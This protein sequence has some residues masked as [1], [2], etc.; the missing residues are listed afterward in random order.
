MKFYK[1]VANNLTSNKN[2]YILDAYISVKIIRGRCIEIN[3]SESHELKK[4]A[5]HWSKCTYIRNADTQHRLTVGV[6]M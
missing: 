2:I 5:R 3:K 4:V 6:Q 1:G